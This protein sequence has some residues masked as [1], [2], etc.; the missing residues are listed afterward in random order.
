MFDFN[1]DGEIDLDEE[2]IP[3]SEIGKEVIPWDDEDEWDWLDDEDDDLDLFG[4][5]DYLDWDDDDDDFLVYDDED[6]IDTA[7]DPEGW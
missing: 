3:R 7:L 4:D 2:F 6:D 5:D 1:G